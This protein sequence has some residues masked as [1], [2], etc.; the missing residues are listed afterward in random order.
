M[1]RMIIT[2]LLIISLFLTYLLV[3]YSMVIHL[4]TKRLDELL[5]MFSYQSGITVQVYPDD[6]EYNAD[7]LWQEI[8]G[9]EK[10]N[11][12]SKVTCTAGKTT[13]N[14][15]ITVV[16][17][18]NERL[19]GN[20]EWD[21]YAD[22]SDKGVVLG[23]CNRYLTYEREQKSYLNINGIEYEVL[24]W[25]QEEAVETIYLFTAGMTHEEKCNALS[26]MVFSNNLVYCEIIAGTNQEENAQS[27]IAQF[28]EERFLPCLEGTWA[29]AD[30]A[31]GE[32]ADSMYDVLLSMEQKAVLGLLFFC[33]VN[34][35]MILYVWMHEHRKEFVIKD[36][37]GWNKN[38]T[39]FQA[40]RDMLWLQLGTCLTGIAAVYLLERKH[41][42]QLL[43]GKDLLLA[44]GLTVGSLI[45]IMLVLGIVMTVFLKHLHPI[46]QLGKRE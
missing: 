3:C 11:W 38:R 1:R 45:G 15:N 12:I 41:I 8:E 19:P 46:K 2:V 34:Y 39:V 23:E 10:Y 17:H 7:L 24:G 40:Q 20:I 27:D 25:F 21:S 22:E 26:S 35:V 43:K 42:A 30:P 16:L 37:Y 4:E 32:E 9:F 29:F 18:L 5:K 28:M 14:V 13:E 36:V 6:L 33:L 31:D 44:S